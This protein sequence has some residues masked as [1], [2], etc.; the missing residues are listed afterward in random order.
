VNIDS[1]ALKPSV[2]DLLRS[3]LRGTTLVR[4]DAGY[5]VARRVWNGAI[6]RHPSGIIVCA[7]AEDASHA[8]RIAA[9]HGLRMTVRGGGHNVAGRSIYDGSLLLDLSKLRQVSVNRESRVATVQGGAVWRDVDG[10]TAREGL[11]T[12]GGLISSTGVGGFTLGG[13]AGWLMRKHGLACD[14]VR[15]AGVVLSD[16]RFVRASPQEHADLY[17][18]LR[19]GAGGLG[20]VTSFEFQLYPLRDVLAGLIVHPAEHAGEALRAFRDFAADAPDE[21]CGLAVISHAPPLP[22]L[23]AAWHGRQVV[24]FAVCWSGD[25]AEGDAA[26]APLRAHGRP[27]VEHIGKM[28]YAQWQQIQDP[29]APR[30]H[31][32]YW[33]TANYAALSDRTIDALAAMANRLPTMRSEI[34]VQH[35]GGAVSRLAAEDSAFAHRNAQFFVNFVGITDTAG[36]IGTLRDGIRALHDEVSGDAML[37]AMTNFADQ[38]DSDTVRRFGPQNADR[39]EAL[40]KKYDSAG[41]LQSD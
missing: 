11:A 4:G 19:G 3:R 8:V 9:D 14:N 33:K 26:L 20:V 21:F 31:Y 25:P 41:I 5:E 7:D 15:S 17:W 27:I 37:G 10:A 13:G 39:L 23:D 32:Y 38:D 29:L 18:G 36:A 30:G 12:T 28:P 24:L 22:F 16:G 34:H 35:M 40:R 6:D 1:A 2:L